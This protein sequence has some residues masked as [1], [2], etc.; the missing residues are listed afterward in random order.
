MVLIELNKVKNIINSSSYPLDLK[1]KLISILP[2][3]EKHTLTGFG[4]ELDTTDSSLVAKLLATKWEEFGVILEGVKRLEQDYFNSFMAKLEQARKSLK[5]EDK[6]HFLYLVLDVRPL[7]SSG[8]QSPPIDQLNKILDYEINLFWHLPKSEVIYLLQNHLLFLESEV[9]LLRHVQAAV[10]ENDWDYTKDFEKTFSDCILHNKEILGSKEPHS[11]SDWIKFYFE[12]G[13]Q[14]TNQINTMQVAEYLF[15]NRQVQRLSEREKRTLSQVLKLLAWLKDPQ[16]D[17][18]EVLKYREGL[19][20][21]EAEE[22]EEGIISLMSR[23]PE[24][25]KLQN[26]DFV[27]KKKNLEVEVVPGLNWGDVSPQP[28]RKLPP[29]PPRPS[30]DIEKKLAELKSKAQK[31][32]SRP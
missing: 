15:K 22:L 2:H 13:L 28:V 1:D 12:S 3:L 32:S 27:V 24:D 14:K 19:R 21:V 4:K 31:N 11:V 7:I 23:E 16:L 25:K 10:W 17:E 9:D 18:L 6:I 26:V 29:V 20:N 30:V 8:Q 5:E